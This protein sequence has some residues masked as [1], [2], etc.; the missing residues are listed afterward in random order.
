MTGGFYT[1]GHSN[2]SLEEF[3]DILQHAGV[4][5][6]VDVR[7]FPRSR[8][9]PV[10]NTDTLPGDLAGRQIGYDGVDAATTLAS[11]W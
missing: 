4:Q 10:F 5:T 2:R 6:V 9:N 8:T 1:V 7:S 11:S 3:M